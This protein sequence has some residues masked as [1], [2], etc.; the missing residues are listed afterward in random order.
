MHSYK[1][2]ANE[3]HCNKHWVLL[4][5]SF[6]GTEFGFCIFPPVALPF[7][8]AWGWGGVSPVGL[9]KS[10]CPKS[11]KP[12]PSNAMTPLESLWAEIAVGFR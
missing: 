4:A 8:W 7:A 3:E 12:A 6:L 11:L 5:F 9:D 1:T 10:L 2:E